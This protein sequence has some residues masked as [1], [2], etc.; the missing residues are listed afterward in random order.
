MTHDSTVGA[1][2][3]EAEEV[4]PAHAPAGDRL[5]HRAFLCRAPVVVRVARGKDRSHGSF[6]PRLHQ[7]VDNLVVAT[8][9]TD[10]DDQRRAGLGDR[11]GQLLGV[12]RM[13]SGE[14][15]DDQVRSLLRQVPP[16]AFGP[17]LSL[18]GAL[19][20]EDQD[21][22]VEGGHALSVGAFPASR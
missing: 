6:V 3:G 13:L 15:F 2:R 5:G 20:V 18:A 8:I 12:A 22:A 19:G 1:V 10:R 21:Y 4:Y 16:Q 9:T 17:L 7:T 11:T 14:Q